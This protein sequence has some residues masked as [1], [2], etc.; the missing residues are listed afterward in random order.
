MSKTFNKTENV[1]DLN[2]EPL[3]EEFLVHQYP[4]ANESFLKKPSK[5]EEV[6]ESLQIME[7]A[8]NR[9]SVKAARKS[10]VIQKPFNMDS[11]FMVTFRTVAS[12]TTSVKRGKLKK[13]R[14]NTN[15]FTF[16]RQIEPDPEDRIS[17]RKERE[18]VADNFRR[19]GNFEYRK[20]RYDEAILYYT[21]ALSYVKDTPVLYVNRAMC[22]IKLKE[23]KRGIMDCDY[24]LAYIDNRYVR[25]WLYRAAAYKRLNDEAN[26]E[27]SVYKAKRLNHTETEFIDDF[28][29]KVKTLL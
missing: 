4:E 5:V 7:N 19:M 15:Q 3:K 13:T 6:I 26:Y 24:I 23:Y 11:D 27:Y 28:L 18:I 17:A 29:E 16:M 25:A 1:F 12:T 9:D 8:N 22:Y 14:L 20:R 21:K 2:V 10:T